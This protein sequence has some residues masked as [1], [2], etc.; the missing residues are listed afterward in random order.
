MAAAAAGGHTEIVQALLTTP[1]IDVNH[2]N[3]SIYLLTLSRV[4]VV[5]EGG[6]CLPNLILHFNACTDVLSPPYNVP[7]H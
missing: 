6:G 1:G 4:V 3:V 5:G 7:Q 2:A